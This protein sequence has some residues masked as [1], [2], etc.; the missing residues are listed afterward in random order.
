M[1]ALTSWR[2]LLRIKVSQSKLF[3]SIISNV[4]QFL[5]RYGIR[6]RQVEQLL[7]WVWTEHFNNIITVANLLIRRI[8]IKASDWIFI[9]PTEPT[10]RWLLKLTNPQF[11]SFTIRQIIVY[12]VGRTV[13]LSPSHGRVIRRV[14]WAFS[15]CGVCQR[16]PV[17][18]RVSM[19]TMV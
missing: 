1:L 4:I 8:R 17:R 16:L 19:H 11:S 3:L 7:V 9:F 6:T 5:I 13:E 18:R 10:T 15:F 12:P 14:G 2:Y